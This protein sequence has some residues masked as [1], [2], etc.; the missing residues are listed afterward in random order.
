MR[1]AIYSIDNNGNK[2]YHEYDDITN[3]IYATSKLIPVYL[4]QDPRC[5]HISPGGVKRIVDVTIKHDCFEC[6]DFFEKKVVSF[7]TVND[8]LQHLKTF[9][10]DCYTIVQHDGCENFVEKAA[11]IVS[12]LPH[13]M[14]KTV[15]YVNDL[16]AVYHLPINKYPNISVCW[17]VNDWDQINTHIDE[18]ANASNRLRSK[19]SLGVSDNMLSTNFLE[20]LLNVDK[21]IGLC[22]DIDV[23]E[24]KKSCIQYRTS[25]QIAETVWNLYLKNRCKMIEND[26]YGLIQC[27]VFRNR[28]SLLNSASILSKN[29]VYA[30]VAF[31]LAWV[32]IF[33]TVIEKI[34]IID[35]K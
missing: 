12:A 6:I 14:C 13:T 32:K 17:T 11:N 23:Y 16:H 29:S 3:H 26:V 27:L 22:I 2:L 21:N 25:K 9:K 34:M 8:L 30:G 35:R 31:S 20:H 5:Q 33:N 1:Y 19:L 4:D 10:A 28:V 7:F 18:L 24:F 15:I